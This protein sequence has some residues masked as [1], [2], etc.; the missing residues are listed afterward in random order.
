M[1]KFKNICKSG[2]YHR[3]KKISALTINL[4]NDWENN[5]VLNIEK[6]LR[7]VRH[8]LASSK[9]RSNCKK[10]VGLRVDSTATERFCKIIPSFMVAN[11]ICSS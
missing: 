1:I 3:G 4:I 9:I 8:R 2:H 6:N 10:L 7:N 11:S 5:T